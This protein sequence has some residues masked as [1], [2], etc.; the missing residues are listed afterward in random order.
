M[1]FP[2]IEPFDTLNP[3][4]HTNVNPDNIPYECNLKKEYS[5]VREPPNILSH[6]NEY[7][8]KMKNL[9][10]LTDSIFKTHTIY[11]NNMYLEAFGIG[12]GRV[13]F[14]SPDFVLSQSP[15]EIFIAANIKWGQG[16][17]HFM[18]EVL[19]IILYISEHTNNKYD[20]VCRGTSF[21]EPFLR[22][23]GVT[24]KI[25][26]E[27]PNHKKYGIRSPTIECGNPSLEKIQLVRNVICQKAVFMSKVGIL[28]FR[29]E[30]LRYI[31]NFQEVLDMLKRVYPDIVWHVFDSLPVPD[32]VRLFSRAKIIVGAHGAGLTNMLFSPSGTTIVEFNDLENPNP[33]YWHLS[34]MLKH[35]HFIIPCPTVNNQFTIN[36]G[37]I[38]AL[39]DK[40]IVI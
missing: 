30:Q 24:N 38:E 25:Y 16:F 5:F 15:D 37:E 19:P 40:E 33:C 8:T 23:I 18:T 26:F 17:Y 2:Y 14:L 27:V 34:E 32:A 11:Y 39:F 3:H 20:I 12:N 36:I 13:T 21:I 7:K 29:K 10:R 9:F 4:I 35:R 1:I 6:V 28:L 22:Y 31:H